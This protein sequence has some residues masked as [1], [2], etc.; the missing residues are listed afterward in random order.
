MELELIEE[1]LRAL[2]PPEAHVH[3][4]DVFK[5]IKANPAGTVLQGLGQYTD[6]I[7]NSDSHG[8]A[9]TTGLCL[10]VAMYR[11]CGSSSELRAIIKSYNER[12]A[13]GR[14]ENVVDFFKARAGKGIK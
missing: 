8:I 1:F 6:L 3:L 2:C 12:N 7:R 10:G 4:N 11:G 14:G 13:R 9:F 5:H